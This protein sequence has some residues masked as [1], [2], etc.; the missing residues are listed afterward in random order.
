MVKKNYSLTTIKIIYQ[1]RNTIEFRFDQIVCL[2]FTTVQKII[3]HIC[4]K[5]ARVS[6]DFIKNRYGKIVNRNATLPGKQ[7]SQPASVVHS[8]G[9]QEEG[10]GEAAANQDP[11]YNLNS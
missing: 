11:A 2:F 4:L 9:G 1:L 8:S 7:K 3:S 5:S 10:Q 6:V